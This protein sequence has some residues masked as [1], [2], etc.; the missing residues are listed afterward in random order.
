MNAVY[1]RSFL[2]AMLVML[3]WM[4]CIHVRS[5][6]VQTPSAASTNMIPPQA[7]ALASNS[8]PGSINE[9]R[10]YFHEL[11]NSTKTSSASRQQLA[12]TLGEPVPAVLPLEKQASLLHELFDLGR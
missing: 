12:D 5:A 7:L 4:A 10:Q 11:A 1:P 2:P 9:E 8:F 3:A 6:E